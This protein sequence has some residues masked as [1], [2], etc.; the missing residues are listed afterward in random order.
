M[1]QIVAKADSGASRNYWRLQDTKCLKNITNKTGTP[2]TLPNKTT[3]IP[4][5]EGTIPLSNKLSLS[6][7][8]ATVLPALKSASLI[9]IGQVCDDNCTMVFT[10]DKLLTAKDKGIKIQVDEANILLRG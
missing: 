7:Q 4:T 2:V 3:I 1:S 5:Q 8:K 10:K 6:A 9:S